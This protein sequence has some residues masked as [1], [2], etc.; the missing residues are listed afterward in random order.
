MAQ[1][2]VCRI[3]LTNINCFYS[4][5]EFGY[6]VLKQ[7]SSSSKWICFLECW[8]MPDGWKA[9]E[10]FSHKTIQRYQRLTGKK[11]MYVPMPIWVTDD[12]FQI[13]NRNI[14]FQ[15]KIQGENTDS[16]LS[17]LWEKAGRNCTHWSWRHLWETATWPGP[18]VSVGLGV[19]RLEKPK[20]S[21]W[22]PLGLAQHNPHREVIL[23]IGSN[24]GNHCCTLSKQNHPQIH[25]CTAIQLERG[26][27]VILELWL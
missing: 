5:D 23:F 4:K 24:S 1:I 3:S 8:P 17:P 21:L 9:N 6:S 15:S 12:F 25:G 16:V 19:K 20:Y 10:T 13:K 7:D 22:R 27:T 11:I 2:N 14:N 18:Y 26:E